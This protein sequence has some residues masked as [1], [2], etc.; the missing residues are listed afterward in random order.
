MH[1]VVEVDSQRL[2][3]VLAMPAG[4]RALAPKLG[5]LDALVFGHSSQL[6]V[7]HFYS[8]ALGPGIGCRP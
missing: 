1:C 2:L 3:A 6:L 5:L 8:A 4:S 7:P